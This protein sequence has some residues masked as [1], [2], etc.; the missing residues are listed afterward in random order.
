MILKSIEEMIWA[1]AQ[2]FPDKVALKSGKDVVTYKKLCDSICAAKTFFCNAEF[3]AKGGTIIIAAGKQLGFVFAYFG[4]HLA[5]LKVVP[6]DVE[7]NQQRFNYIEKAVSPLCVIGFDKQEAECPK[8][9]LKTFDTLVSEESN[10]YQDF[11]AL[12]NTA[13]ILFTTG[14]TGEPKGVPLTFRNEAAAARNIN[15]YIGNKRDDIELLALPISH[16]FGLG[17][18]R[19]CLSMGATLIL[20]G[21]FVNVKR[22]FR[23]IEEEHVTGFTMVPASWKFLQKMSGNQL[24]EY[25]KQI[26]Y[27]EMG[28]AHLSEDDKR[29]LATLF[30]ITR[31]TMHY[32][33]T[34]ASRSA[35]MEFHE[36]DCKLSSVGKPSPNTDIKIFDESGKEL[37][38]NLE[39]ELC[40][41]GEH[42]TSGYINVDNSDTYFGGYFRTGDWGIKD[43]EGYIYLKSRKKE[44]INVGGKKVSPIEIEDVILDIEGVADCAC[45]GIPDPNG[46]LGEV[47]KAFIV[48]GKD[49][50]LEFD[51]IKHLLPQKLESY[52]HPVSYQWIDEIPRTQNGK[53]LRGRL[54]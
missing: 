52:K 25:A 22:I 16:S 20:Q 19:C 27:I 40:V 2:T 44:L 31:V 7:T 1:N 50:S 4:A 41:K 35:F 54:S 32:G 14:T 45:I 6:I 34:E 5:K 38:A 10:D 18:L 26:R 12:D 33:L 28:S 37:P 24:S 51:D 43:T 21:S 53:I 36:D 29:E 3:Y 42:V 9:P 8:L 49:S 39:G 11:P 30:P 15:E 13:D 46:V 23:I 48:K 47:V 17:R